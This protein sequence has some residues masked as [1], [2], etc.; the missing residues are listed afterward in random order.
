MLT[1]QHRQRLLDIAN[2]GCAKGHVVQARAIYEGLLSLDPGMAP[3]SIGLAMSHLVLNEFDA[4]EKILRDTVLAAD[5]SDQEARA[6]LGL[7][8]PWGHARGREEVLGQ[9]GDGQGPLGRCSRG[10]PLTGPWSGGLCANLASERCSPSWRK[11][12]LQR[13]E[14]RSDF[15][16]AAAD[17]ELVRASRRLERGPE[18]G[19]AGDP[20]GGD[21]PGS[22]DRVPMDAQPPVEGDF[23]TEAVSESHRGTDAPEAPEK[24]ADQSEGL[25]TAETDGFAP[26]EAADASAGPE[27]PRRGET[28]DGLRELHD[29]LERMASGPL[30]AEDLF[31]MQYLVGM[32]KVQAESGMKASQKT[33]QGFDSLLRQKG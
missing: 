7:C 8:S 13:A 18:Y 3:A 17:P 5:P 28:G 9:A 12:S 29:I 19:A 16:P 11:R 22:A 4:S 6:M 25:R 23:R 14:L 20:G 33:T 26:R 32:L 10:P 21:V 31:R 27:A 15:G 1:T 2:A 24:I 30:R